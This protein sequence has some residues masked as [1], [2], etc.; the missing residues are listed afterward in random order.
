MDIGSGLYSRGWGRH[1]GAVTHLSSPI[2]RA[3]N[4]ISN[5]V[6]FVIASLPRRLPLRDM[7]VVLTSLQRARVRGRSHSAVW[8]FCCMECEGQVA[9]AASQGD[10]A[11]HSFS[12]SRINKP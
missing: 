3:D 1:D 9:L 8:P 4:D 11:S 12:F 5:N 10:T 2:P 6:N 7:A